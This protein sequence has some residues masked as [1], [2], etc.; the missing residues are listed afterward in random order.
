[1]Y[2]T[3]FYDL[4]LLH[5]GGVIY[6]IHAFWA[7]SAGCSHTFDAHEYISVQLGFIRIHSD[8]VLVAYNY[9]LGRLYLLYLSDRIYLPS[10]SSSDHCMPFLA[11]TVS[12]L[13]Y[14]FDIYTSL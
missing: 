1:M 14:G 8:G 4:P 11:S 12:N 7:P 10:S 5:E 2:C 13:K 3:N 6:S 9:K